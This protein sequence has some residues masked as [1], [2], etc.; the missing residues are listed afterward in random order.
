MEGDSRERGSELERLRSWQKEARE[1]AGQGWR[2]KQKSF[3]GVRKGKKSMAAIQQPKKRA[4]LP[5]RWWRGKGRELTD[6]GNDRDTAPYQWPP[7][8]STCF[9][10]RV[11]HTPT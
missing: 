6:R 11:G 4:P 5:P 3:R 1:G 7:W 2:M 9:Q 8:V 10:Y